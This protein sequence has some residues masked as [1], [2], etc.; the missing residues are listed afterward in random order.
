MASRTRDGTWPSATDVNGSDVRGLRTTATPP[1]T[2]TAPYC[3]PHREHLKKEPALA[4]LRHT[5]RRSPRLTKA[6]RISGSKLLI[7]ISQVKQREKR[8][9]LRFRWE[10]PKE[11]K[12]VGRVKDQRSKM[13]N[14]A[15][16]RLG[17]THRNIFAAERGHTKK[18]GKRPRL[19]VAKSLFGLGFTFL[20]QC[21][22]RV[23][24]GDGQ[25]TGAVFRR[26]WRPGN[27]E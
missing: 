19:T 22:R 16:T 1:R 3:K 13:G 25:H 23:L 2:G 10:R 8:P 14:H 21:P 18:S 4:K 20:L 5:E 9:C 7:S 17:Q 12:V 15:I 11:R 6:S 27:P 26:G 24:R